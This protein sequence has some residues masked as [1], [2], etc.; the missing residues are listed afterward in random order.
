MAQIIV[1]ETP[2]NLNVTT[3]QSNIS[4]TDLETN[5]TVN[6]ASLSSN[7]AVSNET[8]NVVI[9]PSIGVSNSEIR[10]ALSATAPITY[11]NTNG[12]F[13]FNANTTSIQVL[14]LTSLSFIDSVG[15]ITS[16][17][18]L[19]V[20]NNATVGG[21]LSV[22]GNIVG[23]NLTLD[24]ASIVGGNYT[25]TGS[26]LTFN[27]G[28]IANGSL[29]L[30]N[31]I[32]IDG[33][34]NGTLKDFDL[35]Y[36]DAGNVSGNVTLD[37]A[38]GP[39]QKIRLTNNLTGLSFTGASAAQPITVIIQQDTV[40]FWTLD[41]TTYSS[42]WSSW[43]FTSNFKT[44]STAA[45]AYDLLSITYDGT[46]YYASLVNFVQTLIT[47]AELAN[48]NVIVNGTTISLGSSGNISHLGNLTTSALPEGT[49]LYFTAAR[50]R[51]NVSAAAPL[52]YNSGTGE[53][54]FA[55]F[56]QIGGLNVN[57]TQAYAGV[58]L[59]VNKYTGGG[60][61]NAMEVYGNATISEKLT[62]TGNVQGNF[63]IGNGSQLTG[64]TSLTN[65]QVLSYIAT[66][67][68]TVGGN[69]TVNGNINATG[70][71]N[72]QNVEDLYVR[73]QTIVMNAN[74]ASPANVQIV[75]N[76]PSLANTMLKWN[77]QT[78]RWTFTNNGTTYYNMPESTTDLA[79]G[80]NLYYTTARA[81]TA[82]GAYQGNINTPGTITAGVANATTVNATTVNT[83]DLNATNNVTVLGKLNAEDGSNVKYVR[84]YSAEFIIEN[85]A[86]SLPVLMQ[87]EANNRISTGN[88]ALRYVPDT[89][90]LFVSEGTIGTNTNNVAGNNFT[91]SGTTNSFGN[92]TTNAT[93]QAGFFK[94]NGS[95]LTGI[96]ANVAGSEN[97]TVT[98]NI[99]S[100]D[101]SLSNVNSVSAESGVD[102]TI[103]SAGKLTLK[104][105]FSGVATN[106]GNITGDGY[107][108]TNIN[109]W[110][111]DANYPFF[112]Y[113]GTGDLVNYILLDGQ[114]TVGS[115]IIT[116]ITTI[117]GPG[118]AT[119][120]TINDLNVNSL[121]ADGEQSSSY[122]FPPG[123]YVTQLDQANSRI[124]VSQNA[125]ANVDI[126]TT[127]GA[128]ISPGAYDSTTGETI[129][130]TSEYDTNP[131]TGNASL[132]VDSY[133]SGSLNYGYPASGFTPS[134][135]DFVSVGSSSD[136]TITGDI[137]KFFTARTQFEAPKTV[138]QIP[139]GAVIGNG[140]L[141][142]RAENDSLPVFGLNILWDGTANVDQD[143]AGNTPFT[144]L[145]LKQYSDNTIAQ[146]QPAQSGP[147][148][149]FT[150][151][152]G[153]KNQPYQE[154]YPRVNTELGRI[155]WWSPTNET[156]TL[157]SQSAPAYI[158]GLTNRD[159]TGNHNGG[160]GLYLVA[161][162][163]T[164]TGQRGMFVGHQLGNTV[165]A[166][167]SSTTSG[168]SQPI[169]F[170]PMA[171]ASNVTVGG[172][173]SALLSRTIS[174]TNYQWATINHE[175]TTARTGSKIAV[176]N[177]VSTVSARQG[178]LV[179]A[180]DRNDNSAGFGN[181]EWAFKLQPGSNDLVLTE[182]DVVRTT[183][184]GG[185][186]SA[187]A[188]YGDGGNLTNVT[189]TANTFEN[190]I[191]AGQAN[192][193]AMGSTNLT[194]AAGSG[195]T[196]TT[197]ASLDIITFSSTGGYGNAEVAT[198]LA[199]YGSNTI[200]TSGNISAGNITV[201]GV[202]FNT[203]GTTAPSS[204]QIVYN[205][206]YGTHQVGL[207]GSNVMLMGQDLVVYARNDEANTLSKG[208]VVYI[209]GAS[210]DKATVRRAVNNSDD[211]SAT[212]IG[213]VKSDIAAGQL[214]YIV[215]QGVVDG[216]NLGAYTAGDKLYLGNVA[217]TFTNVKP[218]APAHYVFI[219]VVER[220]NSGNG[221]ILV[222]V[223]NGFELDE[224]H[225]IKLTSVQQN[226]MLIRNAG[227]SLWVNQSVSS[228][229]ANT[230]V[231]LKQFNETRVALGNVTGDQ[232]S[233]INLANGSIFTM[234]AT[235]NL[236]ISSL[237]NAVAGSSATLIITQDSTGSRLLTSTMKFA[238]GGKTLSTTPNA[239][240]IISVFYDGT[241]YYATLSKGYA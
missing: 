148:I 24:A 188:F 133:F 135:F 161:S 146:S 101:N 193:V 15:N 25:Q 231:T 74:A 99:V 54:G 122:P 76:R 155:A 140:D 67:P 95:Q 192:V 238:G 234:T 134:D 12:I 110:I 7:I 109:A 59:R 52:T 120:Y 147:R 9:A 241:T 143:Y 159:M 93:V 87:S 81:N 107:A 16:S 42:N 43:L 150:A 204:G 213:I 136:Y 66:Q 206:N 41:T 68:L 137:S 65:A 50:A 173:A 139:R 121:V 1:T 29:Q 226:D 77:E 72:V 189:A 164:D 160:V 17:D 119:T 19:T 118:A 26:S 162:P 98:G 32:T 223:Q 46:K 78:D 27:Q 89:K 130:F 64:I 207:N 185:N 157:G 21:G 92:I 94:G 106:T 209:S 100:L 156:A 53:F 6:V 205:S 211:N 111:P 51:G 181:K 218:E 96:P 105:P 215:S 63:F 199:N 179:L 132:I 153:N 174:S 55:D 37:V 86:A 31:N 3:T 35:A 203:G 129:Y 127:L 212:T 58:S 124:F 60:N 195:M 33:N 163:R 221:Q 201:N 131:A 184:S 28:N 240:D 108:V 239:I 237:T 235:G 20:T 222:R 84:A 104:Q 141:T 103:T 123:T 171:T 57:S 165:V 168:A 90:T 22:A 228:V 210:G 166:S 116:G 4:V 180:L 39:V 196:I 30:S 158:S 198:F 145:L 62:V 10:A 114:I 69:L 224:I 227:N 202:S 75:A 152:Q 113:S 102:F 197:D 236:T 167:S 220:A 88:Q 172:N 56:A 117:A 5:I 23:E 232:S 34:F 190:I 85:T 47:N 115:N 73:D 71:I 191:V 177:G 149:F 170:A 230:N 79:E 183:F 217:G 138:L 233:N 125:I 186:I 48:S 82:I 187:T 178:N 36:Y 219:G 45:N 8:V 38:N 14:G 229:V 182:D 49:N 80:A 44:L 11:D 112:S 2:V 142:I 208:E 18:G 225:D 216:I 194:L 144:Q 13:G 126:S 169:T 40:G 151:A 83:T 200:N 175:N 61:P 214:G 70:N 97:I 91:I 154:T 176:T 128:Y